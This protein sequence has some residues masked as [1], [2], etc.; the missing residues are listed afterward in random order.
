MYN[1]TSHIHR[2]KGGQ[3]HP[4][5]HHTH[6]HRGE[7]A[8]PT[9]HR[10]EGRTITIGGGDGGPVTYIRALYIGALYIYI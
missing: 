1:P 4:Q 6:I 10:G 5:H 2:G 8:G 7:R 3:S 9:S